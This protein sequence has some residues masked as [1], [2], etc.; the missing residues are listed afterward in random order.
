[1]TEAIH[2]ILLVED[3]PRFAQMLASLV[4]IAMRG[5]GRTESAGRLSEAM[6]CLGQRRFDLVF[7]DLDLPDSQG[8]NTLRKLLCQQPEA[9]VIVLTG[10]DG[11]EMALQALRIGALDY[12]VKGRVDADFLRRTVRY[13]LERA[14]W[15]RRLRKSNARLESM[16][17]QLQKTQLM[18]VRAEKLSSLGVLTAGAAHEILNPANVIG[19]YAQRLLSESPEGSREQQAAEVIYRNVQRIGRICDDLRRFSRD[20]PPRWEPFDLADALR[21]CMRPLETEFR[22]KNIGW[23]TR[24]PEGPQVVF[25]DRNQIQQVCLNLIQNGMDAMPE[26]GRLIITLGEAAEKGGRWWELSVADTGTGISPEVMPRIF[27]PFFTT[28]SEDKGTGLG[29]SVSYSIV[30]A[31]GG[32]I[33]AESQPGQGATFIVRLPFSEERT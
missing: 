3:E 6:E 20:E 18:V 15:R 32:T 26:G 1:M 14:C 28:K 8:L 17:A 23:E 24:F 33:W 30:E 22:L 29:L 5:T 19:M 31:H 25:G 2:R 7:L 13:G 27:D 21:Q 4:D 12:V 10:R 16:V 9:P 11:E